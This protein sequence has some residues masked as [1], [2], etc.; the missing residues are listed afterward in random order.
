[1]EEIV[2]NNKI[3]RDPKKIADNFNLFFAN[4]GPN[5]AT[6][7]PPSSHRFTEYLKANVSNS[8]FFKPTDIVEV[9][10]IILALKN[11]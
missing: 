1:M 8:M 3:I 7:I 9:K 5:L 4:V 6:K 11:S 10:Q 2:Q